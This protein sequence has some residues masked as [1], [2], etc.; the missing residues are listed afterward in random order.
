MRWIRHRF[1]AVAEVTA[2]FFVCLGMA[3]AYKS[4]LGE[5]STNAFGVVLAAVA[6]GLV[7]RIAASLTLEGR[8]RGSAASRLPDRRGVLAALLVGVGVALVV[9]FLRPQGWGFVSIGAGLYVMSLCL[10]L[11]APLPARESPTDA[12]ANAR[13]TW[14]SRLHRRVWVLAGIGI[15]CLIFIASCVPPSPM[16]VH[17]LDRP[18][19]QGGRE[20]Q[21]PV[22]LAG[23]LPSEPAYVTQVEFSR[24]G[25]TLYTTFSWHACEALGSASVDRSVAGELMVSVRTQEFGLAAC[26]AWA[27]FA[28]TRIGLDPPVDPRHPPMV[29]DAIH[30]HEVQIGPDRP[31]SIASARFSPD[32]AGL[33]VSVA[34]RS[35]ETV[36]SASIDRTTLNGSLRWN[37]AQRFD[38]DVRR[39]DMRCAAGHCGGADRARPSDRSGAPAGRLR[40]QQRAR[41]ERPT[42]PGVIQAAKPIPPMP[43]YQSV[44]TPA[45]SPGLYQNIHQEKTPA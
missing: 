31:A 9:A 43:T 23:L 45:P 30:A 32:G 14:V 38:P 7:A 17:D 39:P 40:R 36:V 27:G 16:I 20:I 2:F 10:V 19:D 41:G 15:L 4:S 34:L 44:S 26:P 1:A 13:R 37:V 21:L 3:E 29:V 33:F 24:D 8:V 28:V 35:C 42:R 22:L 25:R 6:C 12:A 5:L 18:G 11:M